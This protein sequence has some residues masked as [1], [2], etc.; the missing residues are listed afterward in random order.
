ML[1]A[2]SYSFAAQAINPGMSGAEGGIKR[3][4]IFPCCQYFSILR[5]Q[6]STLQ[7]SLYVKFFMRSPLRWIVFL[8]KRRV[9]GRKWTDDIVPSH[10]IQCHAFQGAWRVPWP[11]LHHRPTIRARH[12]FTKSVN[13]SLTRHP[14]AN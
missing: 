13:G 8:E 3:L 11:P 10:A 14:R 9:V 7:T 1:A 4:T 6:S 5:I 2:F 12:T